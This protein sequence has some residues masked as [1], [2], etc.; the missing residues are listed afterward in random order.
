MSDPYQDKVMEQRAQEDAEM[1]TC[2]EC[3]LLDKPSRALHIAAHPRGE[4]STPKQ[5]TPEYQHDAPSEHY[6]YKQ[7]GMDDAAAMH[8]SRWKKANNK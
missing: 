7:K 1:L 4:Q 2:A 5:G 6:P 3:F 8:P